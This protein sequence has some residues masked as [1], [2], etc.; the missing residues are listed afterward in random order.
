MIFKK[1]NI[2]SKICREFIRKLKKGLNNI[3]YNFYRKIY[4]VI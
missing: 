1:F 2:I 4:N 3:E